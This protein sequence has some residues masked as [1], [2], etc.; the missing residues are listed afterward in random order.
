[1]WASTWSTINSHQALVALSRPP[2]AL[3]TVE[4]SLCGEASCSH[5]CPSSPIDAH[6]PRA[7]AKCRPER[8]PSRGPPGHHKELS[9]PLSSPRYLDF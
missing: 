5:A 6:S 8:A 7:R 9:L 3:P 4:H 1:M 2:E